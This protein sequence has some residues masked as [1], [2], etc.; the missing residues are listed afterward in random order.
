VIVDA[1]QQGS[2]EQSGNA[3]TYSMTTPVASTALALLAQG[4]VG[5]CALRDLCLEND[6]VGVAIKELVRRMQIESDAYHAKHRPSLLPDRYMTD[7]VTGP[8]QRFIRVVEEAGQESHCSRL[9]DRQ[10]VCFVERFTGLIWKAATFK[11]P[12]LNFPRGNVWELPTRVNG[13]GIDSG[14]AL[15]KGRTAQGRDL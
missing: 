13:R 12:A 10:V 9:P 5:R 15:V 6:N 2:R 11:A 4:D 7:P 14:T 8:K 1:Q 3:V